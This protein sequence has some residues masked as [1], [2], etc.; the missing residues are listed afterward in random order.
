MVRTIRERYTATTTGTA[1]QNNS[2]ASTNVR[3]LTSCHGPPEAVDTSVAVIPQSSTIPGES[4][5]GSSFVIDFSN[6]LARKIRP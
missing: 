4:A 6:G 2:P 5:G 1:S 3:R